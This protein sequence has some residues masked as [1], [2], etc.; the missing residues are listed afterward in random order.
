MR[1][2]PRRLD[3]PD[4]DRFLLSTGH[5]SIG[6]FAALAE[7]GVYSEDELSSYGADESSLEMSACETTRGV[8]IT[9]GSLGHG[10][11]QAVGMALGA[12]IG[13]RDFRVFNFL[14]D[15]ELQEGVTWEAAMA[16]SHYRLANLVT[17]VDINNIQAD[18]RVAEVMTVEPVTEKWKAFGWYAQ[19]ID[20]NSIE[21]LVEAFEKARQVGNQ[22][23]AI[24]CY[25][26]MGKGV[27]L[28]EQRPKAH[29]IQ[30]QPHEWDRALAQV[31]G[32]AL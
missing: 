5:Y 13:G 31:E 12:R 8:E 21:A 7:L 6:L 26:L 3:W 1:F 11:S 32:G 28:I 22:P 24:I 20:G 10:L 16:A 4:R 30:V 27:P 18:G 19:S 23:K 2:D 14:S 17:L 25:T 29:F 15:G 9:G